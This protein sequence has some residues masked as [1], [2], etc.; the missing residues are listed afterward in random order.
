RFVIDRRHH[1]DCL[2]TVRRLRITNPC[3]FGR[4]VL[5]RILAVTTGTDLASRTGQRGLLAGIGREHHSTLTV[6]HAYAVHALLVG[7]HTHDLIRSLAVIIEHGVPG[8]AGD[9]ARELIRAQD[10]GLDQ[11]L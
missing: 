11:L 6:V 10:H 2:D 4:P 8:R 3:V 7:N 1:V 9:A 5:H